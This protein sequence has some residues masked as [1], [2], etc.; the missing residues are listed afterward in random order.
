MI[1]RVLLALGLAG[2]WVALWGDALPGTVIA[3]VAA[4]VLVV[5]AAPMPASDRQLVLR[6][7]AAARFVAWFVVQLVAS[8]WSVA[9]LVISPASRDARGVV[10]EVHLGERAYAVRTLVAHSIS[11][12]PGTL[13]VDVGADGRTLYVHVMEATEVAAARASIAAL[14]ERACAAFAPARV[15]APAVGATDRGDAPSGEEAS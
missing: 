8:T 3:G 9:V 1:R 12:T 13:T 7:F 15:A 11:L 10:I 14:E 4:G 6:P 5:C 2:M